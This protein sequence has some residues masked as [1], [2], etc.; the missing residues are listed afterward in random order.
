MN[1]AAIGRGVDVKEGIN[2]DEI[3]GDVK[4]VIHLN[5]CWKKFWP[6]AFHDFCRVPDQRDETGS[7][8]D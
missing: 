7:M 5:G 1:I 4:T 6:E 8:V 3:R 2:R